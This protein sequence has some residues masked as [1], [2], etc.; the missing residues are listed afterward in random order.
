[1]ASR[2][3]VSALITV[4]AEDFI[5]LAGGRRPVEATAPKV[6]G[7]TE[8]GQAVLANLGVTP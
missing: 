4:T 8:L 7:D 1:M 5:L 2:A 6:E 3:I